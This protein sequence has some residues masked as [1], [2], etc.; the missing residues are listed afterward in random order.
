AIAIPVRCVSRLNHPGKLFGIESHLIHFIYDS[1]RRDSLYTFCCSIFWCWRPWCGIF[2]KIEIFVEC[3][4]FF[5]KVYVQYFT[6][7]GVP[8][9]FAATSVSPADLELWQF[10]FIT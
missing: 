8:T 10:H 6:R 1:T 5:A 9:V 3:T 4:E 2:P 7:H